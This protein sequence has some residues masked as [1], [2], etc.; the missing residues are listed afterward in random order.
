MITKNKN[1]WL[2]LCGLFLYSSVSF[3]D[4]E[5]PG[6][7]LYPDVPFIEINKFAETFDD[8]LVID[9][10]SPYEFSILRIKDAV[11]VP[12]TSKS[13]VE[14]I[15]DLQK[16]DTRPI[17]MYCNGKTCMKS[18]KA[19]SKCRLNKILNV[20]AYDRGIMDWAQ[21]L[22][23]KAVLLEK[24]PIDTKKLISNNKFK[25]HL[26]QPERFELDIA[27]KEPL[28][29]DIRDF[30]QRE[31]L[32]LFVG[33]ENSVNINDRRTIKKYITQSNRQNT[34]LYIYDM[35]GKQ[36]RWLQYLLEHHHA[37]SYY[38][39]DG[40]TIKYFKNMQEQYLN[41][42]IS[43]HLNTKQKIKGS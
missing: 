14:D 42:K 12:L 19:V 15:K 27:E 40:G 18:Y 29:L 28:V 2:A 9:V 11:N 8:Y 39:M 36:V 6:R 10:R 21:A 33:I 32:S 31:G 43:R 3:A 20:A 17:V 34:P 37:K 7:K 41:K 30:D 26:L 23:N 13:F 16:T 22:P 1:F 25:K 5:F 4:N 35:A 24:T 38:F